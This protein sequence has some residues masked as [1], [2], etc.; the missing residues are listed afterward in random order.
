MTDT[1]QIPDA[2]AIANAPPVKEQP[3]VELTDWAIL[4]VDGGDRHLAGLHTRQTKIRLTTAIASFLAASRLIQTQSGRSYELLG[5]PT[6]DPI[7][8]L[9]IVAHAIRSGVT[10]T[11]D[12][13]SE[14]W[15]TIRRTT[16]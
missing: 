10:V 1:R 9:A 14:F 8:R 15:D 4:E 2:R 12:A 5:A 3:H 13:S 6:D 16:H 11:A 7:L